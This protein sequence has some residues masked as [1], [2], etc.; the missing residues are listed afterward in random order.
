MVTQERIF[1]KAYILIGIFFAFL[2]M[3]VFYKLLRQ[4]KNLHRLENEK[5]IAEAIS[6]ERE[7]EQIS[8]EL[9]NEVCPFLI[10]VSFRLSNTEY[11]GSE[12][13]K[14]CQDVL[15]KCIDKIRCISKEMSPVS[16]KNVSF[17]DAIKYYVDDY[18]LHKNMKIKIIEKDDITLVPNRNNL[19]YH[20]LQEIVQN[21]FKH[22]QASLLVIEIGKEDKDLLIRTYDNGIGYN[23]KQIKL[24]EKTGYGLMGIQSRVDML[25]GTLCSETNNGVKYNIRIPL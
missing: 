13:I 17:Q 14:I 9:H 20:I 11:S 22:A 19:I 1:F 12:E 3:Y 18:F 21:A 8:T 4:L 15:S 16:V 2:S 10:S 24:K 7:R 5:L 25:N 6:S 23:L